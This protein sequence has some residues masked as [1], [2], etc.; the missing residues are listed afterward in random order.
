MRKFRTPGSVRGRPGN[1][2]FYRDAK[3]NHIMRYRAIKEPTWIKGNGIKG[4]KEN[5][6][7]KGNQPFQA[8][9][10]RYSHRLMR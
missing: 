9:G 8:D 3:T 1:R 7:G 10:L 5:V 6:K 4:I 2:T